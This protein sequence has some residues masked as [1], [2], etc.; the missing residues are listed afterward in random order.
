MKTPTAFEWHNYETG[1]C[2]VDYIP[3]AN[4]TEKDG[5][6][7]I[8]LYEAALEAKL[9][10]EHE[11][12]CRRLHF[13]ECI[14]CGFTWNEADEPIYKHNIGSTT[15]FKVEAKEKALGIK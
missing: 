8:P 10:C 4:M 2:Y 1:H 6:T 13:K 7:K 5:Y 3:R 11:N 14:D 15:D 9:I 12:W